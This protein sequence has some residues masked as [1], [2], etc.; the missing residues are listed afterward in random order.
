ML[1][2]FTDKQWLNFSRKIINTFKIF[3]KLFDAVQG[4]ALQNCLCIVSVMML[5]HIT[6]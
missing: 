6:T 5:I 1:V 2:F 3:C 4:Y